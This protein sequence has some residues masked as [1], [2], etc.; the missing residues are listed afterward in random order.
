MAGLRYLSNVVTLKFD[1][2]RC[3]G[4][5]MCPTVCPH[6]VWAIDEQKARIVDLDGCMECGAC[7]K[8]CPAEAI[9]V[10]AG[11]GCA[12]AILVGALRGTEPDC[13]CA[14]GKTMS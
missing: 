7:A 12:Y 13:C 6:A 8:N 11:V 5:G 2:A 1:R 3:T 9:Q 14:D 10:R 4:C